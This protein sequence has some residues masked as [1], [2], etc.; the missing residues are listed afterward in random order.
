LKT[1]E[2]GTA[3]GTSLQKQAIASEGFDCTLR[4]S[5]NPYL[6]KGPIMQVFNDQKLNTIKAQSR[7]KEH[8]LQQPVKRE[9]QVSR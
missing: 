6:S 1:L 5:R 3:L 2:K 8:P 7:F 9:D 4:N